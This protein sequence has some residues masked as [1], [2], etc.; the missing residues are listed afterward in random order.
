MTIINKKIGARI[1]KYRKEKGITQEE[2]A[3]KSELDY[4]YFNQIE[5]GKRNPSIDALQRIA[6]AVGVSLKDLID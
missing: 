3:Y 6:K 5:M 4:S 2:A 1:R